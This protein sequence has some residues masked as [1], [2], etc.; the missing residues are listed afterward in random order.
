MKTAGRITIAV[1]V[2]ATSFALGAWTAVV[3]GWGTQTVAAT[4]VNESNEALASVTI[5]FQTCGVGGSIGSGRLEPGSTQ[6]LR[7]KVCGEGGYS[8]TAVFVDGRTINS[9]GGYVESGY[10]TTE[11]IKSD[12]VVSTKAL[13]AL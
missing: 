12:A 3:R 2:V 9:A 11:R 8:V 1:L 4:V 6:L 7:Y 5:Q 10:T 13:Y